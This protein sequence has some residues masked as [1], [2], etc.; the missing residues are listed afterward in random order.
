[1]VLFSLPF[2]AFWAFLGLKL[3]GAW[4]SVS[5]WWIA[6]PLWGAAAWYAFWGMLILVVVCVSERPLK[7]AV[8]RRRSKS[9]H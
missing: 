7:T 4:V 5:W 9:W 2:L 3:S 8:K 1:M 6:A